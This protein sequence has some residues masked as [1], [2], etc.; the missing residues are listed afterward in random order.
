[1]LA[2]SV[3]IRC[4][5]TGTSCRRTTPHVS[6]NNSCPA[7]RRPVQELDCQWQISWVA[8]GHFTTALPR[9]RIPGKVQF[10]PSAAKVGGSSLRS[11]WVSIRAGCHRPAGAMEAVW[12]SQNN[13]C[14]C[15]IWFRLFRFG[16]ASSVEIVAASDDNVGKSL[17]SALRERIRASAASLS[18]TTKRDILALLS[19]S[20]R[21]TPP[22]PAACKP[23][24][25]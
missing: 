6:A 14:P 7:A 22:H 13:S 25:R 23:S 3:R 17:V 12:G 10:G 2:T 1:M 16:E 18:L 9:R 20:L 24:I 4:R 21:W 11:S 5:T 15:Y 8:C 19:R